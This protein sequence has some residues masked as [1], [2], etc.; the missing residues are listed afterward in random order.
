MQ[1][2]VKPCVEP[3]V[4]PVESNIPISKTAHSGLFVSNGM[5]SSLSQSDQSIDVSFIIFNGL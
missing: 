2:A 3:C 4:E 1:A 5:A